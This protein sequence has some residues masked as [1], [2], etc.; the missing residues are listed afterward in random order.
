MSWQ[1]TLQ[2][3][4]RYIANLEEQLAETDA[5]LMQN[6]TKIDPNPRS[7]WPRGSVIEKT[8]RRHE[9]RLL[10]EVQKAARR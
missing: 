4:G 2:E 6:A 3:L 5:V 8:M 10:D 7:K 1:Q 9:S